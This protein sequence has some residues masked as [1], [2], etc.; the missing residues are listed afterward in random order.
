M[1]EFKNEWR[2]NERELE[3]ITIDPQ[4]SIWTI[5]A[6]KCKDKEEYKR[7]YSYY[8]SYSLAMYFKNNS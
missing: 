2:L 8:Y 6:L 7:F 1:E 5:G 3:L 4:K